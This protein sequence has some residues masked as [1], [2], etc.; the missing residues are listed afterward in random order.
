MSAAK[1]SDQRFAESK[2]RYTDPRT[3]ERLI[4]VTTIVGAFDSGDK[5]G[6]GAGAA[7]KITKAGGDYRAEWKAKADRGTRVHGY[8]DHW[9]VGKTADV[10]SDDEPYADAFFDFCKAKR[11]EWIAVE[12]AVVSSLGYGGKFDL[13]GL[14]EDEFYLIDCKTGKPYEAELTLQLA[15]YANADGFIL[16]DDEGWAKDIEPMPHVDRWA[17]LYLAEDGSWD[18]VDCAEATETRTRE[19]NQEAA[20][21]AFKAL[22]TVKQWSKTLGGKR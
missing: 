12:R 6:A 8:V 5:L 2:H 3:K 13:I 22:L 18:L 1:V 17:G 19:E 11:P 4:S 20:F 21:D 15:G 7:V 14:I 9:A 10:L 16:Y